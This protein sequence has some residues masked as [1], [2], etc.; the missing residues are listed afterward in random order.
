MRAVSN[1]VGRALSIAEV[2]ER[3]ERCKANNLC[4]ISLRPLTDETSFSLIGPNEQFSV[5]KKYG[6]ATLT[7]LNKA[8]IIKTIST[9]NE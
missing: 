4:Y 3:K 9:M 8:D 2:A 1:S 7:A 6:E 5:H